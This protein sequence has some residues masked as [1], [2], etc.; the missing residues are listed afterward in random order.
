MKALC[1]IG[2]A[3][4]AVMFDLLLA[5]N[6]FVFSPFTDQPVALTGIIRSEV[7]STLMARASAIPNLRCVHSTFCCK[8]CCRS[9]FTS[10]AGSFSKHPPARLYDS[11]SF[12]RKVRTQRVDGRQ[13][14]SIVSS[15][16]SMTSQM[17]DEHKGT[18]A[19]TFA[20]TPVNNVTCAYDVEQ[21]VDV[22]V[23]QIQEQIVD[24]PVPRM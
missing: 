18:H 9:S 16:T 20:T 10:G 13:A 2:T 8:F 24:V 7:S 4:V 6:C 17:T 21:I 14:T 15:S 19:V 11:P 12:D 5:C 1:N 22:P 3:S 23:A